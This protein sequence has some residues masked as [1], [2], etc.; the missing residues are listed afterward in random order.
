MNSLRLAQ[1]VSVVNLMLE[2]H[3]QP[4]LWNRNPARLVAHGPHRETDDIWL[5]YKDETEHKKAGDYSHFADEHDAI[6][7]PAYYALP[8]CRPLIFN[9]MTAICGERL[10]G[11]L[12]YRIPPGKKIHPHVDSGWHVDYYDKFNVYLQADQR[13]AFVYENGEEIRAVSGDVYHFVNN[14]THTVVNTGLQDH[15]VMTVCIRIDKGGKSC[16]SHGQG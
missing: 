8:A 6:W 3:R 1:N 10:G 15:I 11:V 7:Y 12:I 16:L 13:T 9:L 5:R 4:E 14:I 2:L